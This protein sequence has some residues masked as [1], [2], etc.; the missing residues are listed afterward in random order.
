MHTKLGK[1]MLK[2]AKQAKIVSEYV[3]QYFFFSSNLFI[4]DREPF[5]GHC[6]RSNG[7]TYRK[8]NELYRQLK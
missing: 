7:Y 5:H 1:I 8:R 6:A 2:F 4:W 3:K